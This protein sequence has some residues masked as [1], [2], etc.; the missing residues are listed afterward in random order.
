M[1]QKLDSFT[2]N[3]KLDSSTTN[4]KPTSSFTANQKPSFQKKD[5][6]IKNHKSDSV[7]TNQKSDSNITNQKSD[8]ATINQKPDSVTKNQ[9]P[10]SATKPDS[11]TTNQK[12][13]SATTNQK[14]DPPPP[15]TNQKLQSIEQLATF[16]IRSKQFLNFY[17]KDQTIA[18][19]IK[20]RY[21]KYFDTVWIDNPIKVQIIINSLN[22]DQRKAFFSIFDNLMNDTG[23]IS[24]IDACPG[25]GKT[26]LTACILICYR[27]S[28]C[29]MVYTNKLSEAMNNIYFEGVSITCCKFLINLLDLTY[30]KVKY[31]WNT[32]GKNMAEKCAEVQDLAMNHKPFHSFYIMDENSVVSPFFIYFMYHLYRFH[33]IHILFIGDQYQQIPITSTRYHSTSNYNLIK[34]ISHNYELN[35]NMRQIKDPHFNDLLKEFLKFFKEKDKNVMTF[36]VKYFFYDKLKVLFYTDN[37][38][39]AMFFAQHHMVLKNRLLSYEEHLKRNNTP[40]EKAYI[41][42]K[43]NGERVPIAN[44]IRLRKF[45]PYILLV[46]GAKYVYVPSSQV[47]KV[48]V[49]KE[50]R[51]SNLVLYCPSMK[52]SIIIRRVPINIYFASEQLIDELTQSNYKAVN[53]YPLRELVSTYHAAQGLTIANDKIELDMDCAKINSFYVGITRIKA[54]SQLVKIHTKD[55]FN[56][57]YTKLKSDEYFYKVVEYPDSM[58]QLQFSKCRSVTIFENAKRNL[59]IE[60]K[61]YKNTNKKVEK[62]TDLMK[63][64][65]LKH[66]S[67]ML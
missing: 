41:H 27:K 60:K 26:F 31:L 4:Q 57:A 30:V 35:I 20:Q 18:T 32:K 61:L 53:Q 66:N 48:V 58:E 25:T 1:N 8:S 14:P 62:E 50:I 7:T 40:F 42:V 13:D 15:T 63:Y 49:L 9:K 24:N 55:L 33:K 17:V 3:Q 37:D 16:S 43:H 56:L 65:K 45:R 59:K 47:S 28:S 64:M 51:P 19:S 38:F 5:S 67:I 10:D 44:N 11:V 2:M 12:S 36:D 54:L 6:T 34:L 29:Y 23:S 22:P 52:R 46:R 39:G 21:K